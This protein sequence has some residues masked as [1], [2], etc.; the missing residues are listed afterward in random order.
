MSG[1]KLPAHMKLSLSI[2]QVG[3]MALFVLILGGA[4]FLFATGKAHM[5][6]TMLLGWRIKKRK[7]DIE[8]LDKLQ[9]ENIGAIA[10]EDKLLEELETQRKQLEM[11]R[12]DAILRVEGM[13]DEEVTAELRKRGYAVDGK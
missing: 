6:K 9:D 1:L 11:E 7:L 8:R 12:D 4:V 10:K 2:K 13:T 5:V 3:L